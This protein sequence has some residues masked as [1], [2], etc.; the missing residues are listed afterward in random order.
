MNSELIGAAAGMAR[1]S[2]GT[3]TDRARSPTARPSARS[4]AKRPT[5]PSHTIAVIVGSTPWGA[6][7]ITPA[8]NEF[9]TTL[10]TVVGMC[11]P[12]WSVLPGTPPAWRI[13]VPSPQ[14]RQAA[15]LLMKDAGSRRS[16]STANAAIPASPGR[17]VQRQALAST[18]S[19]RRCARGERHRNAAAHSA[20]VTAASVAANEVR[21]I[22]SAIASTVAVSAA[23]EY[24]SPKHRAIAVSTRS[25]PGRNAAS[26]APAPGTRTSARSTRRLAALTALHYGATRRGRGAPGDGLGRLGRVSWVAW[27]LAAAVVIGA[28]A[29]GSGTSDVA[30]HRRASGPAT[31][32]SIVVI[33][34]DDQPSQTL[35]AMPRTRRLLAAHGVKFTSFYDSV[36]LCCPARAALLTGRYA[37]STHVYGNAPPLGGAVTFRHRGDDAQTLAVWLHRAGYRTGLFGKYLNGYRGGYVPPGWD[38]FTTSARY[39]GGPGYE[40]GRAKH[41][42]FTTYMPD[43]MGTRAAQFIRSTP[44]GQ[45]LFAYYAPYA[46]HAHPSPE[47]RFGSRHVCWRCHGWPTPD[48]DEKNVTDKPAFER[49]PPLTRPERTAVRRFRTAQIR[50]LMS[51]DMKVGRI[52]A[53]LKATGRLH[54]TIIVFLSDNGVMWGSHRLSPTSKRN[55]YRR[56]SRMPLIVRYDALGR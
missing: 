51:V 56:A 34:T 21:P 1:T 23:T 28:G 20:T 52:V 12:H 49:R 19:A 48:F 22:T 17:S 10:L 13:S 54:T 47:P 36:A 6:T 53:A 45:P 3:P 43:Y 4:A 14:Y 15:S 41:Y 26:V 24:P 46:P 8:S 31:R 29:L 5:P 7:E 9:R 30:A 27:A 11:R 2:A 55:P 37:H 42:P 18:A 32:P 40:Q 25:V 35:W 38:T 16:F 44:P 39:W 33:L 50:T